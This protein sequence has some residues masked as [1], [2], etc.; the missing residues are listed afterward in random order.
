MGGGATQSAAHAAGGEAGRPLPAGISGERGLGL[1][2]GSRLGAGRVWPL[3][4]AGVDRGRRAHRR[5]LRNPTGASRHDHAS[6]Q[7]GASSGRASAGGTRGAAHA[8]GRAFSRGHTGC[9]ARSGQGVCSGGTRGAGCLCAPH[10]GSSVG[11]PQVWQGPTQ[12]QRQWRQVG[13]AQAGGRKWVHSRR[14]GPAAE[15]S[16][17]REGWVVDARPEHAHPA[18]PGACTLPRAASVIG[19]ERYSSVSA[20]LT[21]LCPLLPFPSPSPPPYT[22]AQ[23]RQGVPKVRHQH[24]VQRRVGQG[25]ELL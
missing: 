2:P 21:T 9:G 1:G 11:P 4:R 12:Q 13:R 17:V 23:R 15:R 6:S 16:A 19:K 20:P 8:A 24:H 3:Q 7:K 14:T 18:R 5:A 10:L 25:H 22:H